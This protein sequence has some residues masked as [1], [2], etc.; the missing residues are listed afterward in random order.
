MKKYRG[1]ILVLSIMI[2]GIYS[3]VDPTDIGSE[4]LEQDRTAVGFIDDTL[5]LNTTIIRGDAVVTYNPASLA[6]Q[7]NSYLLGQME[8][9]IFGKT[10]SSIY[11]QPR[12]TFT[13]PDFPAESTIDSIVLVLPYLQDSTAYYGNFETEY[14]I[15]VFRIIEDLSRDSIYFSNTTFDIDVNPLATASITPLIG[16]SIEI[17]EARGSFLDTTLVAPQVRIPLGPDLGLELFTFGRDSL[18]T[19][20]IS[21]LELFKGLHIRPASTTNGL[22]SF[23]L[24]SPIGGIYLY[25]T[26]TEGG[27]TIKRQYQFAFTDFSVR[28]TKYEH[29]HTGAFIEDYL[30]GEPTTDSLIFIQGLAGVDTK[31]E[32]PHIESLQDLL[33]NKAELIVNYIDIPE[34]RPA[35][36]DPALQL[37]LS[38]IDENGNTR[39]I[40]DLFIGDAVNNLTTVFG[41]VYEENGFRIGQYKMNLT[42]H[43]QR[44]ISGELSN[45]MILS[46]FPKSERAYRSVLNG[47][48]QSIVLQITYSD[49]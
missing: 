3:C 20:N 25:Y 14:P 45:T 49:N 4:L 6:T 29:D 43:L 21:F 2:L 44:M 5:T 7:L 10:T 13:D 23:D 35:I 9:A 15:E 40:D 39:V 47:T 31:I 11:V 22:I 26:F 42:S 46:A 1:V 8:D 48:D 16:D 36:Y 30:N 17:I 32:I 19:D 12:L 33:I 27:E 38:Y 41:G 24:K 37:A 34:D 28:L 18:L